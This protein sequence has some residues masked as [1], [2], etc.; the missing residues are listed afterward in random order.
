MSTLGEEITLLESLI[1]PIFSTS[2]LK[3]SF[4]I[5]EVWPQKLEWAQLIT[6]FINVD[7]RVTRNYLVSVL[8]VWSLLLHIPS[9]M[10]F[11]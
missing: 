7:R 10:V 8:S 9:F 6:S 11:R 3:P 4:G 1:F 2:N 5:D